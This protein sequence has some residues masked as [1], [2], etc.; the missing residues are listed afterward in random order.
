MDSTSAMSAGTTETFSTSFLMVPTL[1]TVSTAGSI[2]FVGEASGGFFGK[3]PIVV[4]IH[5][6]LYA[7]CFC[8]AFRGGS[9]TFHAVY[10]GYWGVSGVLLGVRCLGIGG[11][12]LLR[13]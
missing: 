4:G 8:R 9:V 3:S 13:L 5:A 2:L 11:R 10:G 7:V 1:S 12:V 6:F